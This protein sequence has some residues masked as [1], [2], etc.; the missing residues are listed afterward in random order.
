MSG[1]RK[2]TDFERTARVLNANYS[3]S[4][5]LEEPLHYRVLGQHFDRSGSRSFLVWL[6][7]SPQAEM[8]STGCKKCYAP[9]Y[10][11][12]TIYNHDSK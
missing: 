7:F 2:Q 1:I 4:D 10:S 5:G 6:P 12:R 3:Q 11:V 9:N 8:P